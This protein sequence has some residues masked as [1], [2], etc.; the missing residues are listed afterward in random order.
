MLSGSVQYIFHPSL[1]WIKASSWRRG[2][3]R[4]WFLFRWIWK[5]TKT[6]E[7][8]RGVPFRQ[9][10]VVCGWEVL[11]AEAPP[12]PFSSGQPLPALTA[13]ILEGGGGLGSSDWITGCTHYRFTKRKKHIWRIKNNKL[14]LKSILSLHF[15][16]WLVQKTWCPPGQNILMLNL[17]GL[18]IM[19]SLSW[20]TGGRS[21]TVSSTQGRFWTDICPLPEQR[22]SSS[23][24]TYQ[25]RSSNRLLPS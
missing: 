6:E 7:E 10:R 23:Q 18:E 11:A 9:Q 12:H 22:A 21:P 13:Q 14:L 24:P 20:L 25:R 2:T 16:T 3:S 5:N 17:R 19:R 8:S 1:P 15:R 4:L